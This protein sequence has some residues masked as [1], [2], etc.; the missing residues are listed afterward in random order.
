MADQFGERTEEATPRKRQE[1]HDEGRIPKSQELSVA[2]L[3]LGIA[4]M[5][6]TVIPRVGTRLMGIMGSSLA[7]LGDPAFSGEGAIHVLQGLGWQ[8]LAAICTV[9]VAML[10]IALAVNAAQARGVLSLEPLTPNWARISPA[11][12]A[13][14]IFGVQSAVELTKS[15]LKLVIVGVAIHAA[16]GAGAMRR[17]AGT[18]Q[19]SPAGLLEVVRHYAVK[20][21]LTAGLAYLALALADYLWQYWQY[22]KQLRMTKEEVKQEMKNAEGDPLLKQRMRSMARQKARRQM[23]RDVPRADVVIVNPTHRAIAIQYD[24]EAAPAP[25]VLAMG[26]RKVA[27]RIKQIALTHGVPVVENRPLAIALLKQARVGMV[28]PVE[29]YLAVAEVLAFVIRQ[30][31]ERG[32]RW[33]YRPISHLVGDNT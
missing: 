30:R 8:T 21:V 32:A 4:L 26:Q 17:I 28:I 13:K 11:S 12:N 29:L 9:A 5:L 2:V 22:T 6:T 23:F 25:I 27:E 7:A 14:R 15:L 1:A 3:L 24:P 33:A 18:A 20:L 10:G 16:L 19:Q 31:T